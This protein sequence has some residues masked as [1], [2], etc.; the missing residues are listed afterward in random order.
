MDVHCW[1]CWA[2]YMTD[3][4][5]ISSFQDTIK[6]KCQWENH[7]NKIFTLIVAIVALIFIN[8]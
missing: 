6:S 3:S 8:A 5:V 7:I 4:D 1:N 2:D